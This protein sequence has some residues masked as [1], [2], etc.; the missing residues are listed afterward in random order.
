MI[1]INDD[2]T[3]AVAT[4]ILKDFRGLKTRIFNAFEGISRKALQK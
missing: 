1:F 3:E 4:L 2:V